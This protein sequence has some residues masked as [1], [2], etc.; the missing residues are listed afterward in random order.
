MIENIFKD[1]LVRL[2]NN[3]RKKYQ[4]THEGLKQFS[5]M[6]QNSRELLLSLL[7]H[8]HNQDPKLIGI[9]CDYKMLGF[10]DRSNFYKARKELEEKQFIYRVKNEYLINPDMINHLSRRQHEYF[11][12]MF[13]LKQEIKIRWE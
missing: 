8:I 13:G 1:L 11:H 7:I 9:E 3:R 4:I 10:N 5:L 2:K 12:K 6:K